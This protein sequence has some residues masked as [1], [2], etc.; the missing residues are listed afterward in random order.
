MEPRISMTKADPGSRDEKPV[1]RPAG[2]GR[3]P[4][5]EGMGASNVTA[6]RATSI[7]ET[8]QLMEAVVE[9]GNMKTAYRRVV[10]WSAPL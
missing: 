10:S 1:A 4:R 9:R 2:S 5:E 7:L 6:R 8:R 3:N